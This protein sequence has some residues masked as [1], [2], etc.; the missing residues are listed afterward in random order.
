MKSA[1]KNKYIKRTEMAHTPSS[2]PMKTTTN[3]YFYTQINKPTCLIHCDI[4]FIKLIH[5]NYI[6]K[7]WH[8]KYF[9]IL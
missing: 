7:H 2:T 9:L 5:Y 4:P 8:F 6:Y 1:K 3:T